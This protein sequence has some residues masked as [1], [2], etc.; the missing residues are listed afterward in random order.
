MLLCALCGAPSEQETGTCIVTMQHGDEEESCMVYQAEYPPQGNFLSVIEA[1][2]MAN[3]VHEQDVSSHKVE[4]HRRV[5]GGL[6][7]HT[8]ENLA[9]LWRHGVSRIGRKGRL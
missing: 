3:N 9:A 6:R 4:S 1:L 2:I 7:G 5:L 8:L